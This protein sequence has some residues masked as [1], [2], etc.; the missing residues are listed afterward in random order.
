MEVHRFKDGTA[1]RG[2][3]SPGLYECQGLESWNPQKVER[4]RSHT[5]QSDASNTELLFR[6]IRSENQL[7]IY[8]A[9][10]NYS[11]QLSQSL[12]ETEPTSE[13][14][15]TKEDSVN[16]EILK[17]VNSWEVGRFFK[18]GTCV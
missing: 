2:H 10:S 14:F 3:R 8:G 1:V 11:G 6:N 18:V 12:N 17:S 5:S 9:V 13:R 7:S 16:P 15:T 4:K